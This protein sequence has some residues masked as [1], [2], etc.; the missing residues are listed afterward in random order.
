MHFRHGYLSYIH[1]AWFVGFFVSGISYILMMK[2]IAF[3]ELRL[4]TVALR[5][6]NHQYYKIHLI[7]IDE[8][9][10]LLIKNGRIITADDDYMAD[11]FI[12]GET[13]QSYW[14]ESADKG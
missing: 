7:K 13:I 5:S 2:R 9:M 14:K 6:A 1:Y 3:A 11:I 10:S 8:I 12:E 4:Q